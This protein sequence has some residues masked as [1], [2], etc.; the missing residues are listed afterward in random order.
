MFTTETNKIINNFNDYKPTFNDNDITDNFAINYQKYPQPVTYGPIRIVKDAGDEFKIIKYTDCFE[1]SL[2]RFLHLIFGNNGTVE[3]NKVPNLQPND[4]LD[5]YFYEN[6]SFYYDINYYET[7][8][9]FKERARWCDFLNERNI[10]KYKMENKYEVC[11]SLE[12]LFSFFSHFFNIT[13]ENKNYQD[14]LNKLANIL[15]TDNLQIRF[16]L[17]SFGNKTSDSFYMN[18]FI[19]IFVNDDN[20]YDWEITQYFN[21]ENDCITERVTGHSDYRNSSYINNLIL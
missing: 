6:K 4:E 9:G 13:F 1:I 19:K 11:A 5:Y 20:L 21:V 7:N 8:L 16:K 18:S 17:F 14:N 2:L 12:N 10:F 15:S 3:L